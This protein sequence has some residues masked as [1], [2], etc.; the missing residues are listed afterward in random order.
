MMQRVRASCVSVLCF[1][2]VYAACGKTNPSEPSS[3]STSTTETASTASVTVPRP[4]QPVNGGQVRFVEQPVILSVLNAVVTKTSGTTY[5]FEVATDSGFA[6]KVQARDGVPEGA[7][8]TSIA[9]E[10]LAA[11]RDYYWHARATGGGTTGLFSPA[12]KFTVG[13]AI[14]VNPPTPI[15]PLTGSQTP[16]RPVLRVT[17]ATRSGPVGTITYR[18]EIA[19]VATFAT[20]IAVGVTAE[21]VNETGFIPTGNLPLNTTLYWRAFALDAVNGITSPASAVQSFTVINPS[22]A[23][24][25]AAQ[26]GVPLWPGVQPPGTAGRAVMGPGWTVGFLTSFNGVRFLSPPLDEL[27]IFDLLD[28]GMDPTSALAWMKSNGYPT[29]GVWYAD[30]QA[31]GFAYQYM[32]LVRGTWELVLRS[33]A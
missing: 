31:I 21:G 17:N 10:P 25:V 19:T 30:V 13:P 5:T 14:T 18:F 3:P 29:E 23:E 24:L 16:P 33:G 8:Q 32:A 28:R 11:A 12:F 6:S 20:L 9:L 1:A 26:L 27:Q 2:L 15:A 22:Q 4:L 7:G